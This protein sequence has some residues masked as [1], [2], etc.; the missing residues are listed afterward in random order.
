MDTE[1][2]FPCNQEQLK[3]NATPCISESDEEDI[4][5]YKLDLTNVDSSPS[6][7]NAEDTELSNV[8]ASAIEISTLK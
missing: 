7:P 8:A 4:F 3:R 2:D 5:D 1:F 6:C